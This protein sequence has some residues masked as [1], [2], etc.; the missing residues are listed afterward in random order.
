MLMKPRATT[1]GA[2]IVLALLHAPAWWPLLIAPP[3]GLDAADLT[4]TVAASLSPRDQRCLAGCVLVR[5]P[6]T[7]AT[8]LRRILPGLEAQ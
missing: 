4:R 7:D 2:A 1:G 6:L 3:D 8:T 5:W